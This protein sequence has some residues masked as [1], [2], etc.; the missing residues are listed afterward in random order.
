MSRKPKVF[1]IVLDDPSDH[2]YHSGSTVNGKLLVQVDEPQYYKNISILFFGMAEVNFFVEGILCRDSETCCLRQVTVWSSEQS[3]GRLEMGEYCFPFQFLIPRS[4]P[5]SYRE[6]GGKIRYSVQANI[7]LDTLKVGAVTADFAI[8]APLYKEEVNIQVQQLC[9]ITDPHLLQSRSQTVEKRVGYN[10][11]QVLMTVLLPDIG[12]YCIGEG[13]SLKVSIQN[14]SNRR[15][16]LKASILREVMYT[17]KNR[18]R[19]SETKTKRIKERL[20]SV[21]SDGVPPHTTYE[22]DPTIRI[23]EPI[24]LDQSSCSFIKPIYTLK[25]KAVI[26]WSLSNLK[27]IL[28]LSVGSRQE[29][30]PPV[31]AEPTM[32]YTQPAYNPLSHSGIMSQMWIPQLPGAATGMP[33]MPYQTPLPVSRDVTSMPP[34]SYDET[35]NSDK[36]SELVK[37]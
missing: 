30:L 13:L 10:S 17:G 22:W 35:T 4:A 21:E 31:P 5:S 20:L 1:S 28:P 37:L 18:L 23:P 11:D 2:V 7:W 8:P 25:V 3:D 19:Q 15:L 26:P 9:G 12:F 33:A 16:T 6:W 24:P 29:Q 14:Q 34:P 27:V 32:P 36:K